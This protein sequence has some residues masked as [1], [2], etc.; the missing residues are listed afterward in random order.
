MS[1]TVKKTPPTRAAKPAPAKST[2]PSISV[3]QAEPEA[4]PAPQKGTSETM[5]DTTRINETVANNAKAATDKAQAFFG[6]I[7]ERAKDAVERSQK[8]VEDATE[9][10]KG[11]VEAIVES[12]KVAAKGAE[13]IL[14]Y[15]ADYGRKTVEQATAN[16][17]TLAAAKSPTEVFKLQSD[18][19]KL[20]FDDIVAESSKFAENYLKLL[21]AIAQP[22]SNRVAVAAEKMKVAA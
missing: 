10:H 22:L 7:N 4:A 19:A 16:A 17:K 3:S 11:N 12:T 8:L 1:D 2:E 21:G 18:Y 15:S 14:R 6:D 20:A 13:E 5:T 9:F